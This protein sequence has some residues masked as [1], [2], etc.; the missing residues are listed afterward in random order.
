MH[1]CAPLLCVVFLFGAS[2]CSVSSPDESTSAGS[3]Y[4]G[5]ASDDSD[6]GSGTGS[7]SDDG[8]DG[9]GSDT[10]ADDSDT[11]GSGPS[12]EAPPSAEGVVLATGCASPEAA[13]VYTPF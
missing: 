9:T 7:G 6:S 5:G 2:A 10:P 13:D 1:R 8:G 4:A 12:E 3:D 11:T